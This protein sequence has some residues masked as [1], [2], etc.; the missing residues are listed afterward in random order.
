MT[1]IDDQRTL[2]DANVTTVAALIATGN[3]L[4]PGGA[5]AQGAGI[6]LWTAG[7]AARETE[8]S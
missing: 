3:L 2:K 5:V 7:P 4:V 1:I 6:A 8:E